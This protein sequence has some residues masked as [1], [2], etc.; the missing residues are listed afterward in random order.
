MI[1]FTYHVITKW[2]IQIL[3]AQFNTKEQVKIS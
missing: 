3:S 1:S 2:D